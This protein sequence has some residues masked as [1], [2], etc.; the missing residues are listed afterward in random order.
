[1]LEDRAKP[2]DADRDAKLAEGVVGAGGEAAALDGST[3]TIAAARL[4]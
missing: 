4:G 1:V 3:L 2:G